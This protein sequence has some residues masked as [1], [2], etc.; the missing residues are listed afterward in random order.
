MVKQHP[1]IK[2][3]LG[4]DQVV[5][6][7][8]TSF[9]DTFATND[10]TLSAS[11]V[12]SAAKPKAKAKYSRK[13]VEKKLKTETLIPTDK[14]ISKKSNGQKG[15]PSL[16]RLQE[17]TRENVDDDD[18]EYNVEPKYLPSKRSRP[19]PQIQTEVTKPPVKKIHKPLIDV[20]KEPEIV[21]SIIVSSEK[22][23]TGNSLIQVSTTTEEM[24]PIINDKLLPRLL[25]PVSDQTHLNESPEYGDS[26]AVNYTSLTLQDDVPIYPALDEAAEDT[27]SP[28][29]LNDLLNRSP[30][31]SDEEMY[32]LHRLVPCTVQLVRPDPTKLQKILGKSMPKS[33]VV[34]K[35]GRTPKPKERLDPSPKSKRRQT[36]THKLKIKISSKKRDKNDKSPSKHKSQKRRQSGKES[37]TIKSKTNAS[38]FVELQMP[39]DGLPDYIVEDY[40]DYSTESPGM[41]LNNG[42]ASIILLIFFL[43]AGS[44]SSQTN[45]ADYSTELIEEDEEALVEISAKPAERTIEFCPPRYKNKGKIV[46]GGKVFNIIQTRRLPTLPTMRYVC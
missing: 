41:L 17:S 46:I 10:T 3:E 43:V 25:S 16:K 21:E 28:T 12:K 24:N 26:L 33:E 8:G 14:K 1:K 40:V 13:T 23:T 45:S 30:T 36:K 7:N 22:S 9:E 19:N 35:S 29:N 34:T 11:P 38:K 44:D 18:E 31:L 37:K 39:D 32:A 20:K 42:K 4:M 27:A 2:A 6:L 5:D 15:R